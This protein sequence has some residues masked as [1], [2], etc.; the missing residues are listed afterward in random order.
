MTCVTQITDRR[1]PLSPLLTRMRGRSPGLAASLLGGA[2]AAGLG[3]GSFAVLVMVLWISSPYPDS[4]PDGALHVAAALWLLAHGVELI[5]TDTLSGL[6]M[7]VGVTPLLLLALP[8]WLL[9]RAAR[10]AADVASQASP[11]T[12]WAGVV[13]GYLAVAWA[14]ALYA[15]GGALR[16][17]WPW[18]LSCL[19]LLAAS[20]AGAGIWTAYGR[21]WGP[22][23]R[24]LRRAVDRAPLIRTAP[25][26][27]VRRL[28]AGDDDRV[29][30]GAA[31]AAA[32]G[33]AVLVGGGALLV[34]V[35]LVWHGETARDSFLQLTGGWS[36]RFAVLLLCLALIPNAAVWGASYGLGPGVVLTAGH[37]AGPLTA[38]A[39]GTRAPTDLLPAFPL[40]AA[41]PG[42]G[43]GEPLNWV[44]GAVPVAAG[45]T[46]AWFVV[47][48]GAGGDGG[49]RWS[50]RRTASVAALAA[51]L[52]G[53][54]LGLLAGLAGGPLGVAALAHFGPVW[55]QVGPA[56]TV[57]TAVVALP[58]AVGAHAWKGRGVPAP[59]RVSVA[60][61]APAP[62]S[63][64]TVPEPVS[65]RFAWL[66]RLRMPRWT[67]WRAK[68]AAAPST[69][70]P[71]PLPSPSPPAHGESTR[72]VD[73]AVLE[74]V[75]DD[76]TPYDFL[77]TEAPWREE[78][79]PSER[80]TPPG[81]AAQ[82]PSGA[83]TEGNTPP[84]ANGTPEPD[85]ATGE[86][87]SPLKEGQV[88][89][90]GV[91]GSGRGGRP[92]VADREDPPSPERDASYASEGADA[93]RPGPDAPGT[94]GSEGTGG[95]DHS[96]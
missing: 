40:L 32:A 9:H 8:A 65:R 80:W 28:V 47:K 10:E 52:C 88:P 35:S 26:A 14:A 60:P 54:L 13:A 20:G 70:A 79:P 44:S 93:D 91:H 61:K 30:G 82:S 45:V 55:W 68:T 31:R 11:R 89:G 43:S 16:P 76:L 96:A 85:R 87:V 5:R 46:L 78:T 83:D 95:V 57:W 59:E 94:A 21:P 86:D 34:A 27:G 12:A 67:P 71:T 42:S 25:F 51:G 84:A 58:V 77:P 24:W 49:E 63:A 29:L 39:S 15:S 23:P 74:S 4:G 22:L 38:A 18:V 53:V 19:P 1:L 92:P 2:L 37:V 64:V 6:P 66:P 3:L 50:R 72:H 62:R 7:P 17:S 36:G 56:A 90:T 75:L 48:A 81:K 41:V 73:P 69:A 33:V